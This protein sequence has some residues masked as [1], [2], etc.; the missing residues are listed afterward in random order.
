[1]KS[2]PYSICIKF[3]ALLA[4][5][6]SIM[7]AHRAG[8]S[9]DTKSSLEAAQL[10]EL[11]VYTMQA[12]VTTLDASGVP[13]LQAEAGVSAVDALLKL[14]NVAARPAFVEYQGG[15]APPSAV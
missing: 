7:F 5:A 10:A 11:G 3:I 1:M 9:T 6:A 15:V 14:T 4:V 2:H 12:N 8:A 13:S